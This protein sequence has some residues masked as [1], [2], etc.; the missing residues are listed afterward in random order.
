MMLWRRRWGAAGAA[1]ALL[2]GTSAAASIELASD[3]PHG[4]PFS[5][6]DGGFAAFRIG[7]DIY[8]KLDVF[9]D[10]SG[11]G[12]SAAWPTLKRAAQDFREGVEF[13]F[14]VNLLPPNHPIAHTMSK[15]A[16]RVGSSGSE[17][18]AEAFLDQVFRN[19]ALLLEGSE[20]DIIENWV[21]TPGSTFDVFNLASGVEDPTFDSQQLA[22]WSA[23]TPPLIGMRP[24]A[25][26]LDGILMTYLDNSTD[27]EAERLFGDYLTRFVGWKANSHL[28]QK[29]KEKMWREQERRTG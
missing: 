19:Q 13:V 24:T 23:V 4:P 9:L 25:V 26:Y 2:L 7:N 11:A 27:A 22:A 21:T 5:S 8:G 29:K 20:V 16:F 14:H 10:L 6:A 17:E 3:A 18:H 12:S 28:L 1:A 15:A